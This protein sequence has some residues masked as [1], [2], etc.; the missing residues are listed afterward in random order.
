[1]TTLGEPTIVG[2]EQSNGQLSAP[3]RHLYVVGGQQRALR[4]MTAVGQDWY[5]YQKGVILELDTATRTVSTK[6]EYVSPPEA[7]PAKSPRILFKSGA[8]ADGLLYVCTQT[9]VL[10]YELPSFAVAS[11]I[12]LPM[13]N[14]LHHVRPTPGGNLLVANTG[15]DTVV[16]V[17]R[18]GDIVEIR[19]VLGEDPWARFSRDVDYRRVTT[20]K[21]HLAHPNNVF[22]IGE[23]P[24]ATRF[25]QRD[26]ISLRN[27]ERRIAIG[28]ERV[29]DGYVDGSKVYFT[30]VD[31]KIAIAN[32]DTLRIEQVIDLTRAHPAETLLGWARGLHV[33]WP[34]AWVGFSR[35]RPTKFRENLGWVLQGFRR[36][37][38]T[39][40]GCYD[41]RTGESLGQFQL[42]E[43]GIDAV[44]GVYPVPRQTV[45]EEPPAR[46]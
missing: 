12:S 9:E 32:V 19:N 28:L 45:A 21:P 3:A 14:D 6:V 43:F 37:F 16:E 31:G 40:V 38:G 35:I 20:T 2:R 22:Y 4:P 41:L 23:E 39:H 26:A 15:L 30:T 42:E 36:D 44:F 29:H 10:V 34:Y 27:P 18:A 7:A 17:T 11:Y 24:W 46:R 25:E 13:F 5:E 1:M 33:E 8:L